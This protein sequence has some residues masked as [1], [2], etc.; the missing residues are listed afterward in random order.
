MPWRISV[1]LWSDD[2]NA[3]PQKG[4][5]RNRP[6]LA[7]STAFIQVMSARLNGCVGG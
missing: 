5:K 7:A 2:S 3:P 6:R 4:L 1:M